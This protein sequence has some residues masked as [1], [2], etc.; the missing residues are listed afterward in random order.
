MIL[1]FDRCIFCET[2]A[3]YSRLPRFFILQA[4]NVKSSEDDQYKMSTSF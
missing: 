2:Y 3:I 4:K 1:N